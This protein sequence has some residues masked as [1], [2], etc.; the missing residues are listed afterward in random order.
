MSTRPRS[1][2]LII[3]GVVVALLVAARLAAPSFVLAYVNKTLQ[4]LDGFTG[5]VADIDLSLWRGAYVIK[6]V[7]IEKT[8]KKE[9]IPFV[10]LERAD[11]SVQWGPLLHGNIVGEIELLAPKLNLVA[12]KSAEPKAEDQVEKRE[13]DKLARGEETSW[14]TQVKQLVPLD[15]NRIAISDGEFHYRDPYSTPKVDV[16]VTRIHGEITNLTNSEKLSKDMVAHAKFS[17]AALGGRIDLSGGMDPYAERPTFNLEAEAEE[18]HF[19][20]LNDFLKAYANVDAEQGTLS[21]YSEVDSR[22]GKFK[23]YVKP[24]TRDLQIL[25]WNKEKEGFFGKLW[26][27]VVEV[28]KDIAENSEKDQVATRVPFSGD[29]S[30]PSADTFE[31]LLQVLNNAF[32][33]ALRRGLEPVIGDEKISRRSQG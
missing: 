8:T 18:L 14:Q 9:P 20:K 4:G 5:H 7:E 25:K 16:P 13:K 11:I 33:E 27:G 10:S 3:L 15:I 31:A 24:I 30:S 26:E 32:I 29:I 22:G 21:I 6:G 28:V 23:G 17:A 12:E 2:V 1:K 19:T